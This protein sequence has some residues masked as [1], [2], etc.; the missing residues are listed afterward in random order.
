M[1]LVPLADLI[2]ARAG[3][4]E[5]SALAARERGDIDQ[6]LAWSTVAVTLLTISNALLEMQRLEEAA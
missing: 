1:N 6:A 5:L 4:Y 3:Q 2:K